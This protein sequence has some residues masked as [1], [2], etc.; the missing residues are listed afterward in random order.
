MLKSIL[1][2]VCS[3]QFLQTGAK[4]SINMKEH[5]SGFNKYAHLSNKDLKYRSSDPKNALEYVKQ[6]VFGKDKSEKRFDAKADRYF[7]ARKNH[8][9]FGQGHL[10]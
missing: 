2:L 10:G 4:T 9:S 3:L 7:K 5:A 8:Q 6:T 1:F